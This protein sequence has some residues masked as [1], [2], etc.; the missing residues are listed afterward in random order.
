MT[1]S[2]EKKKKNIEKLKN[3][4][5][6]PSM[7]KG[8][9]RFRITRNTGEQDILYTPLAVKSEV[10]KGDVIKIEKKRVLVIIND[11]KLG[12][13]FEEKDKTDW[14]DVTERYIE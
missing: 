5:L 14:K 2:C 1:T 11:K 8:K 12:C 9:Q 4:G 7:T 13:P 6:I 3:R 10:R